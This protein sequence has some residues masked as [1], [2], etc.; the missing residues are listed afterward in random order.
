MLPSILEE[1]ELTA[2][3]SGGVFT[4][5]SGVFVP[6]GFSGFLGFPFIPIAQGTGLVPPSGH[7]M[8][9]AGKPNYAHQLMAEVMRRR[10]AQDRA[11]Y[12]RRAAARK[13]VVSKLAADVNLLR[14][15]E[16][17]NQQVRH[18]EK[19]TAEAQQTAVLVSM[20]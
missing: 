17:A 1:L 2:K 19:A 6:Q 18:L 8:H 9:G 5:H 15:A 11:R 14:G 16:L 20:L 10:L 4:S 7:G 13:L 12:D 3:K